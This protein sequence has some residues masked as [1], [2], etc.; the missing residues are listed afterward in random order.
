MVGTDEL[1]RDC[2][3]ERERKVGRRKSEKNL[4]DLCVSAV[5]KGDRRGAEDAEVGPDGVGAGFRGRPACVPS[6]TT[7]QGHQSVPKIGVII[8]SQLSQA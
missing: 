3:G 6:V 8:S 5:K 2:E 7:Y 4:C 1:F